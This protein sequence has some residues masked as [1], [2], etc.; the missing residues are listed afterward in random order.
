MPWTVELEDLADQMRE[1]GNTW[2]A[3]A[4]ELADR[5]GILL[6]PKTVEDRIQRRRGE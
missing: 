3:I 6:S 5:T 4:A 1:E 2:T